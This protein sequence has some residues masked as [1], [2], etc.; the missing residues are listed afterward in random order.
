[1]VSVLR[2][3]L[4]GYTIYYREICISKSHF[5]DHARYRGSNVCNIR[6]NNY[7]HF[8]VCDDCVIL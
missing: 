8:S 1:M 2:T 5:S 7:F 6:I 3:L 4:L